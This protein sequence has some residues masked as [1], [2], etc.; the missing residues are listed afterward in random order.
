MV[1]KKFIYTLVLLLFFLYGNSATYYVSESGGNDSNT[2]L[3]TSLAWKTLSRVNSATLLSGDK[4]L[5]KRGDTFVGTL[6]PP[7]SAIS[8]SPVTYGAY[9]TGAKPI[10][11]SMT[12]LTG[13]TLHSGK[14]YKVTGIPANCDVVTVDGVSVSM[15]KYPQ[16]GENTFE[17][18]SSITSITDN[19]LTGSPSWTGAEVVIWKS[20]WTIDRGPI[21][22]HTTTT[23]T[24]TSGSTYTPQSSG[25]QKY[26]IQ[27]SLS[28]LTYTG[29][30][31]CDGSNFYMY[32]DGNNPNSYVVKAGSADYTVSVSSKNY[33][34][35]RDVE[36][37][38]GNLAGIYVNASA[39]FHF[40]N[41]TLKNSGLLGI[42][43]IGGSTVTTIDSCSISYI[44][45]T[46]IYLISNSS[47]IGHTTIDRCGKFA[48]MG[49]S[50]G[51]SHFGL[52]SKG[53]NNIT[54]YNTVT[55]TG[56]IPIYWVS[57]GAICRYNIVDTYPTLLLN[58][59][60]G[61]YTFESVT[62]QTLKRCYRNIIANST[63]NGLYSDGVANNVEFY[64]N[65][66]YNVDKWGIHM[67]EPVNNNVHDNTFYDFGLAGI[68]VTNQYIF[69]SPAG[70]GNTVS[71]NLLI[72]AS[73]GQI[74]YSLQ[75]DQTNNVLT[76]GISNTNTF[77][78]DNA[79]TTVFYNRYVTPSWHSTYYTFADWK[80]LTGFESS[81]SYIS[82]DLTTLEFIYNDTHAIKPF[83]I[84]GVK[85]NITGT[86][87]YTGTIY[88]DPYTSLLLLPSAL[89]YSNVLR[90]GTKLPKYGTK[91]I[92]IN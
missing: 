73:S 6:I 43:A 34:I 69:G 7:K 77:V 88:L 15:G 92:F 80:T 39:S 49:G 22:N 25:G 42:N 67:N 54:E 74:F 18:Y 36:I 64:E 9:G 46:G 29:A 11:T 78:A 24:Y 3:S 32:F 86:T 55:N 33:N 65:T 52:Y 12:T 14:I 31:Y 50:S 66:V 60:G 30:W 79:A 59:G 26:Y 44:N 27:R 20:N 51:N 17:S 84:T 53:T 16:N 91:L 2:G 62:P 45:G 68:D 1:I 19:Q 82:K 4:V 41:S 87:T 40:K 35:V 23:L 58:D 8:G 28:T 75:D 48:G 71:N 56:Y 63:A 37:Q 47:Y 57:S 85:T 61:I 72:Q 38:G 83:T 21:T 10:I 5:F 76:F 81:G 13:W 90:F 70:S 89:P